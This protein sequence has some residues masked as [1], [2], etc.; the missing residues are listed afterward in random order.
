MERKQKVTIIK[1]HLQN[2]SYLQSISIGLSEG[3]EI[4]ILKETPFQDYTIIQVHK[5]IFALPQWM[6]KKL[7]VR[8]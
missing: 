1:N 7:E 3:T 6:M 2:V 4:E 8:R 5:K